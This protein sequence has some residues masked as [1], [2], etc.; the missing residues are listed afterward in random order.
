MGTF[1]QKMVYIR[2]KG[3]TPRVC[4]SVKFLWVPRG[5]KFHP[6]SKSALGLLWT[7]C[8][9]FLED[10]LPFSTRIQ[11]FLKPH[12]LLPR[13]VCNLVPRA[14]FPGCGGGAGKGRE[15]V[16][17]VSV[18]SH[19]INKTSKIAGR[20]EFSSVLRRVGF[21]LSNGN[22]PSLNF[23]PLRVKCFESL[24]KGQVVIGILPT[25]SGKSMLFHGYTVLAR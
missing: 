6:F 12:I 20:L 9:D 2:V 17:L 8:M 23:K 19:T 21:S 24:L 4:L 16:Y 25:G 7:F 13:F 14:L 22:F 5:S 10:I 1:L 3:W 15:R 18:Q 11:T